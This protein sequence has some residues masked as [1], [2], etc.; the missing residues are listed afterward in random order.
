MTQ[1]NC[2]SNK[3]AVREVFISDVLCARVTP[4]PDHLREKLAIHELAACMADRPAEILPRFVALAMKLT[5]GVTASLSI[6]EPDP[7]P[8]VFR[9]H[10]M[11]GELAHLEGSRCPRHD[12]PCGVTL[13][14]QGTVL[15]RH[16]ERIYEW[17]A[18]ENIVAP[19]V[20]LVP[21]VLSETEPL[22]TLWIVGPREG[23]FHSGHARIASELGRFAGIAVKMIR[24]SEALQAALEEQEL[25]AKEMNHRIK[26]LFAMA[27]TM[28]RGT[29]T[30]TGSPREMAEILTG[31]LHA[32]ADAHSLVQ[33]RVSEPHA[34]GS[35][36]VSELKEL[37]LAVLSA[38][39]EPQPNGRSRFVLS[40][41]EIACGDH[42]T[43]GF[44]LV[45]HEL[46]TNAAKYGA[47][48]NQMGRVTIQWLIEDGQVRLHWVEGGGPAIR[49]EPETTGF[50]SLL[51][52]RLIERQFRGTI[53]FGW[54]P[55]GLIV[56]LEIPMERIGL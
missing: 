20:L 46:A 13:D 25:L 36:R 32:L 33:R 15:V 1:L 56:S 50:G 35:T 11:Q 40:G 49:G 45:F 52:R 53:D 31:R 14:Q 2:A 39:E 41:P 29:A 12:S 44:A 48:S 4:P 18:A 19:E 47:L 38:H 51:I 21:L 55:D 6:Y 17:I 5:G 37:L 43:N 16:P 8:G 34:G 42:A 54:R 26:N 23:H 10:C 22:G 30:G 24:Q 9:W 27:D 7:A 3:A 28:I